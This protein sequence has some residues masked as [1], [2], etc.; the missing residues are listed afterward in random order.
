MV[1]IDFGSTISVEHTMAA[2]ASLPAAPGESTTG[3]HVNVAFT[4]TDATNG[5]WKEL[6]TFKTDSVDLTNVAADDISFK[7][8]QDQFYSA[9]ILSASTGFTLSSSADT[10]VAAPTGGTQS[11]ANEFV[12][13][14]ANT[15]FA[16]E[17]AADLLSNETELVADITNDWGTGSDSKMLNDI[18]DALI[19]TG[20]ETIQGDTN[21]GAIVLNTLI[22]DSNSQGRFIA[23]SLTA[24][25]EDGTYN[26]IPLAA[27]D[28]L[29]FSVT[30]NAAAH[31][32][33]SNA[34]AARKYK[35]VVTL[36]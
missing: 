26:R 30:I 35:F 25:T 11:V 1:Q 4:W 8:N 22:N 29:V 9:N 33:G 2:V 20:Y 13:K 36:A 6:F 3:D 23:A 19:P 5:S 16:R 27:G 28:E 31:N 12:R 14:M 18:R 32:I 10:V 34:V 7:T 17:N 21:P 15:I 24:S